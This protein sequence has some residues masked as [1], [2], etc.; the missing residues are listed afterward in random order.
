[1]TICPFCENPFPAMQTS[2]G[3]AELH[4]C[5]KCRNPVILKTVEGVQVAEPIAGARD[6]REDSPPESVGGAVLSVLHKS[7]YD[8][9]LLEP[10]AQRL[11][12]SIPKDEDELLSVVST[13]PIVAAR[14]VHMA[15]GEIFGG[16]ERAADLHEAV[17]RLGTDRIRHELAAL[18]N[19]P[20]FPARAALV[21]AAL[22]Q[23]WKNSVFAAH[24]A[25]EIG[26]ASAAPN[27][28][29]LYLAGLLHNIGKFLLYD[30]LESGSGEAVVAVRESPRLFAETLKRFHPLV[31]LHLAERWRFP[32]EIGIT[33]YAYEAPARVPDETFLY[34]TQVVILADAIARATGY[35][36]P[37]DVGVSLL[38]HPANQLLRLS[39]V[40]IGAIRIDLSDRLA[41]LVPRFGLEAVPL[42]A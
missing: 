35:G 13:D 42:V 23:T 33:A 30:V 32:L 40:R 28:E 12:R 4:P 7:R 17:E 24:A 37:L 41:E 29:G 19:G 25:R 27:P 22:E 16:L 8:L 2:Y 34:T 9:P 38:A 18:A 21:A 5:A 1:M 3:R 10:V 15:N 14:V 6:I 11:K 39:D 20:V 31:A 26:R 36:E